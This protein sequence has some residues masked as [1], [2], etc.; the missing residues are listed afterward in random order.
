MNASIK[1]VIIIIAVILILAAIMQAGLD[2]PNDMLAVIM[3]AL[4]VVVYKI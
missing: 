3:G 1:Y 4:A 2:I